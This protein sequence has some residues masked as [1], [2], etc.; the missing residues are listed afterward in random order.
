VIAVEL[1]FER[2]E[3]SAGGALHA[4]FGADQRFRYGFVGYEDFTM[5]P[6]LRPGSFVQ[7]DPRKCSVAAVA[8][9]A[10]AQQSEYERPIYFVRTPQGLVCSWC[11]IHGGQLVLEPRALSLPVRHFRFPEEVEVIGQVVGVAMRLGTDDG[12]G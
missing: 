8:E 6:I 2:Q 12:G 1:V 11:S 9:Q 5:Y 10:E 3:R 4:E 7:I